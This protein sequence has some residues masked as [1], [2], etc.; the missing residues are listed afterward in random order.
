MQEETLTTAEPDN[1]IAFIQSLTGASLEEVA[2]VLRREAPEESRRQLNHVQRISAW[3]HGPR[4]IPA[5]A[6]RILRRW[7]VRLW[8][9]DVARNPSADFLHYVEAVGAPE[10]VEIAMA[11]SA[12]KALPSG[13]HRETIIEH[14]DRLKA[15]V[16]GRLL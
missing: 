11:V 7:V 14:L 8:E 12:A 6:Q 1:L 15:I 10:L 5:W 9:E 13:T 3:K 4:P 16:F 2:E